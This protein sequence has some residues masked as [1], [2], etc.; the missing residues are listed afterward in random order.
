MSSDKYQPIEELDV[1]RVFEGLSDEVWELSMK[2][3]WFAKQ[4]VGKQMV[5]AADSVGANLVEGD[6]RFSDPEAIHFF[7]IARGSARELRYWITRCERRRLID[8]NKAK[9]LIAKIHRGALML[10]Q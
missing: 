1:F 10:N 2:F 5:R 8:S 3:H 6:G 9:D 4:T 7:F